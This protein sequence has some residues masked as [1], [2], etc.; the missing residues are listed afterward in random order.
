VSPDGRY[1][2]VW[3][4]DPLYVLDLA[5]AQRYLVAANAWSCAISSRWV[6]WDGWNDG[7]W[8]DLY[9]APLSQLEG[10]PS[11][12]AEGSGSPPS[13]PGY[14]SGGGSVGRRGKVDLSAGGS[15]TL[16]LDS[17]S[18]TLE[19]AGGGSGE[20]G[21]EHVE[22]GIEVTIDGNPVG[23]RIAVS[24]GVLCMLDR[25]LD[26]WVPVTGSVYGVVSAVHNEGSRAIVRLEKG[27]KFMVFGKVPAVETYIAGSRLVGRVR[28]ASSVQV[29]LN[30]AKHV[31]EARDGTF[32]MDLR[33]GPGR[34]NL[35]CIVESGGRKF[36]C[37]QKSFWR[38]ADF[39]E[40]HWAYKTAGSF[41]EDNPVFGEVAFL[42]PD[43][44]AK[45]GEVAKL[46]K[47]AL[48]LPDPGGAVPFGDVPAEDDTLASAA[49]AVYD[50]GLVVGYP[51][52]TLRPDR[53][54]S[55]VETAV[56][57]VRLAKRFGTVPV[58]ASAG[59]RDFGQVPAWAKEAVREAKALNLV[60]GYPDGTFKPSRKV[61][62][63]ESAVMALRTVQM[64]P[65]SLEERAR[66]SA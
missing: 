50:A 22:G 14:S 15:A 48:N 63:A 20:A 11:A 42:L 61:T 30:G 52:G 66:G 40:K 1:A 4:D 65:P 27:G 39:D 45:R 7:T 36:L 17:I 28:G 53:E 43:L 37:W 2:L 6:A 8:E 60:S 44:P 46:L 9:F 21:C 19:A 56:L 62:R 38:Y 13:S 26:M 47:A 31:V 59:F 49:R 24:G 25:Q 32:G 12:P 5:S 3:I 18:V 57:M 51:D 41:L 16:T 54:I 23:L 29:V 64:K 10:A 55:R 33:L 35:K 58:N 34:H